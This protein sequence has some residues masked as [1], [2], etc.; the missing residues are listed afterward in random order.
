M[1]SAKKK[2]LLKKCKIQVWNTYPFQTVFLPNKL[3]WL[4]CI[5]LLIREKLEW[6]IGSCVLIQ[7]FIKKKKQTSLPLKY[8]FFSFLLHWSLGIRMPF[9]QKTFPVL[10]YHKVFFLF[11]VLTNTTFSILNKKLSLILWHILNVHKIPKMHI[12]TFF[13]P[14]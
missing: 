8:L 2:V 5:P 12:S 13:L 11:Q 3:N 14:L 1:K 7:P 6:I 4:E 10:S 9:I